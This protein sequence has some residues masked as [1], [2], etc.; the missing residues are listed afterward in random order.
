MLSAA[1]AKQAAHNIPTGGMAVLSNP[2][3]LLAGQLLL[4]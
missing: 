3:K 4:C 1:P 2:T